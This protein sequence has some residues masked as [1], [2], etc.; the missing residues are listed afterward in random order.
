MKALALAIVTIASAINAQQ[1]SAATISV[2]IVVGD[3][4]SNQA[5][6]GSGGVPAHTIFVSRK[7]NSPVSVHHCVGKE[8]HNHGDHAA[9]AEHGAVRVSAGQRI[10]WFSTTADF[11]VVSVVKPKAVDYKPQ[12]KLAPDPLFDKFDQVNSREVLSPVVTDIGGEKVVVVQLYKTTFKIDGALV[13]PDVVCS[14]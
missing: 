13:D 2:E 12:D 1:P 9:S 3:H 4:K 8:L 10:R 6:C 5:R 11:S 14:M 7:E